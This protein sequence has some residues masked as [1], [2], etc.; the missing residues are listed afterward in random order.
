MTSH[1]TRRPVTCR[2]MH[3]VIVVG[4]WFSGNALVS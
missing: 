4:A 3:D 1:I 2:V